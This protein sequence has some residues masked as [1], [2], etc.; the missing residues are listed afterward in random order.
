MRK[1]LSILAAAIALTVVNG[2]G[3]IGSGVARITSDFMVL[4]SD[5]RV[6]YEAGAESLAIEAA[7]HLPQALKHVETRQYGAFR[8]PVEIYVFA[9]AKSFAKFSGAPEVVTGACLN[10][11]VY[12]SGQLLGKMDKVRGLLTHEL[13]HIQLSQTLGTV[14]YNRTLPR[15]FR[16]G[17][18]IYVA[19]GGGATN[20]SEADTVKLFLRGKYF[21]PE[22]EG[23]LLNWNLPG[24]KDL[25]PMYFYRQSGMFVQYLARRHPAQFETLLK[26]L[27]QGNGFEET[28][29]EAFQLK[30]DDMLHDYIGTLRRA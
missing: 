17:L 8:E 11:E 30:A 2:C 20:A 18:A 25:E 9:T 4:P 15:W 14:S 7:R 21:S 26:G 12:L 27:Q 19:D 22:T 1:G 6:S 5:P 24:P 3:L 28:F 10:S 13:S 29:T 23:A 16:E